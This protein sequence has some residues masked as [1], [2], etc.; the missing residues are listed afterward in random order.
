MLFVALMSCS[1]NLSAPLLSVFL[2]RDLGFSYASYMIVVTAAACT[3]FLFQGLWG[4]YGDLLGNMKALRVA[5]WG[6]AVIPVLWMFSRNL[7]YLFFVQCFAGAVW[8]GFNML[9]LNFIMEAVTPEKRIRCISYFNVMNSVFILA[10][11]MLGGVLIHHLPLLFG[12][13]FLTLF[14]LSCLGRIAVMFFGSKFVREVRGQ[15]MG[16]ILS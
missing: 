6:I 7:Y 1:V 9:V 5:G 16:E 2:L 11:A 15:R 14:L 4:K 13:S 8:G 12:Y 3:G 10:G